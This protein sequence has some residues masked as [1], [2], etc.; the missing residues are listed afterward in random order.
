M[1]PHEEPGPNLAG[2]AV[3]TAAQA[4]ETIAAATR[5]LLQQSLAAHAAETLRKVRG[6]VDAQID[7]IAQQCPFGENAWVEVSLGGYETCEWEDAFAEPN[8]QNVYPDPDRR[9][10]VRTGVEV[11]WG[12]VQ[13]LGRAQC[14]PGET[15]TLRDPLNPAHENYGVRKPPNW[16]PTRLNPFSV[17][18]GSAGGYD[19]RWVSAVERRCVGCIGRPPPEPKLPTLPQTTAVAPDASFS[20]KWKT[21]AGGEMQLIQTGTSV[22]GTYVYQRGSIHGDL[23]GNVLTCKWAQKGDEPGHEKNG[24]CQFTLDARGNSFNGTYSYL[25]SKGEVGNGGGWNGTRIK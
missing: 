24:I 1:L 14:R 20:G 18:D 8:P 13:N 25:T 3:G 12:H 15:Q 6:E 7:Q 17:R 16:D 4:T 23:D 10:W 21:D 19:E 5:L 22:S 9:G 11:K 2:N